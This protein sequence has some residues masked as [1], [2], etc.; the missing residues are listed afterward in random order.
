VL[1]LSIVVKRV[2]IRVNCPISEARIEQLNDCVT[3]HVTWTIF[4][5]ESFR[6]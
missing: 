5:S 1:S 2:V 6:S 3:V 4:E